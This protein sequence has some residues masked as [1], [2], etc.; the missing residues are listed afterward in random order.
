MCL[1][2]CQTSVALALRPE[3]DAESRASI[4]AALATSGWIAGREMKDQPPSFAEQF[5]YAQ[6]YFGKALSSL[7]D[8]YSH[9]YGAED[10]EVDF[11]DCI[12]QRRIMVQGSLVLSNNILFILILFFQS[13][14]K[15]SNLYPLHP[16]F[17]RVYM[18]V[19]TTQTVVSDPVITSMDYTIKTVQGGFCGRE[20]TK[21]SGSC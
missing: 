1:F 15:K 9:I 18:W 13:H 7:T 19:S 12:M 5:G 8:T 2:N 16:K 3:L 6:S 4:Q 10:G 14:S 21:R 17:F 11:A 20:I